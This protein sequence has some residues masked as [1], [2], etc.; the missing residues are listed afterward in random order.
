MNI[1]EVERA[2]LGGAMM[3][4]G[5]FHVVVGEGVVGDTFTLDSHRRLWQVM[6]DLADRGEPGGLV[7]VERSAGLAL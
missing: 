2:I 3:G 1:P 7:P 4:D 6:V 5:A